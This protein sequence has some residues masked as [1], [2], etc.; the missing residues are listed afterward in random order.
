M[1]CAY[2]RRVQVLE[3]E[4]PTG[5][6]LS[7][8]GETDLGKKLEEAV[9]K[10]R[11]FAV[12]KGMSPP[13]C[14]ALATLKD[15]VT[16][17]GGGGTPLILS[18]A[19]EILWLFSTAHESAVEKPLPDDIRRPL[20]KARL[21]LEQHMS[22]PPSLE[23][24]AGQVGMSLTR[25]KEMFPR[26]FGMTPYAYLRILRME[27]AR[28]LLGQGTMTVTEAAFDVGYSNL[29]HFSK[30]FTEHFGVQPSRMARKK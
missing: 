10:S 27:R 12:R 30:T 16:D 22:E 2:C 17:S 29:S 19:L 14:Q 15:A 23:D 9:V 28:H 6:F 13:L 11:P 4:A 26:M 18:R 3:L 20:V 8:I 25:F 24:L 1:N 5:D 21:L 7:L